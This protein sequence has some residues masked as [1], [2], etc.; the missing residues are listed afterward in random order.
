MVDGRR[1]IVVVMSRL[2]D[3]RLFT[4][5]TIGRIGE[6]ST[7]SDVENRH[8]PFC[9]ADLYRKT[10]RVALYIKICDS[11]VESATAGNFL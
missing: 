8:R 9:I 2:Q 7:R 11:I 5:I 1:S 4:S 3:V 10:P 6:R